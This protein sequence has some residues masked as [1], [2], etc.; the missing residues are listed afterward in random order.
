MARGAR[1][2]KREHAEAPAPGCASGEP[3]SREAMLCLF[4]IVMLAG[5][6]GSFSINLINLGLQHRGETAAA[7]GAS[8]AVQAAGIVAAALLAVPLLN[9]FGSAKTLVAGAVLSALALAVAGM[10]EN[11]V[12]VSAVRFVYG[13]GLGTLVANVEYIVVARAPRRATV[14]AIY[15]TVFAAGTALG[16]AVVGVLGSNHSAYSFGTAILLAAALLVGSADIRFRSESK[17]VAI[18]AAASF[19]LAPLAFIAALMFGLVDNGI[20]S[21]ASVF[22]V[23]NGHSALNASALAS[24]GLIGALL[25]Q[26]PA[27]RLSDRHSPQFVLALCAAAGF[28]SIVGIL[29]S[30]ADR[31]I[32]LPL[33]IVLGGACEG[34]YTLGLAAMSGAMPRSHL[35]AGNACFVGLC[36]AGEVAGPLVAGAG[37]GIAGPG[38]FMGIFALVLV[39]YLAALMLRVDRRFAPTSLPCGR[40]SYLWMQSLRG[41]LA[42]R[43]AGT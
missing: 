43:A 4:G 7:I 16:P 27:G 18:G 28:L 17:A 42:P 39:A 24:A 29:S 36:G 10:A 30:P 19:R 31:G 21:L 8:T 23:Q 25:F 40:Q 26:I 9:A 2:M 5:F 14:V 6:I 34:F 13:F 3:R 11:L 38:G 33:M 35:A 12:S 20:L 15:G 1:G 37:S 22:A 32:I 41:F